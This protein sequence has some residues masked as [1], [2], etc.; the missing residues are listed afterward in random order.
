MQ[1]A[2]HTGRTSLPTPPEPPCDACNAGH[3]AG[4]GRIERAREVRP[5][6]MGGDHVPYV[7]SL[8]FWIYT[9]FF[10]NSQTVPAGLSIGPM[11]VTPEN[12]RDLP[13]QGTPSFSYTTNPYLF[14]Y[15]YIYPVKPGE[16]R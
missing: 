14:G 4:A 16:A 10:L 5:V 7:A 8:L 12:W 6:R 15:L 11:P 2:R 1:I 9:V 13:H 3:S